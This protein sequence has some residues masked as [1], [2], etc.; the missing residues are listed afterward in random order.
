MRRG[1]SAIA[2][3]VTTSSVPGPKPVG[4]RSGPMSQDILSERLSDGWTVAGY[5]TTM[6]AAGAMTHSI[7]LQK[8]TSLT[9]VTIY[10]NG[11]KEIARNSAVLAPMP[12]PKKG[13]F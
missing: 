5:A 1:F 4:P 13:I 3:Q 9:E 6:L 7:L 10:L 12:P 2:R 11:E 8:G